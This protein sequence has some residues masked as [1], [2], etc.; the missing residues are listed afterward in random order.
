MS[1]IGK[2]FH[3]LNLDHLN[4]RQSDTQVGLTIFCSLTIKWLYILSR[5]FLNLVRQNR[6]QMNMHERHNTYFTL[7]EL[8]SNCSEGCNYEIV[9]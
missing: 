5:I 6:S 1:T 9:V 7:Q 2:N 4:N 8:I 3:I